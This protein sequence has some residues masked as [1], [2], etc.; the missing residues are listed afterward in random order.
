MLWELMAF[1]RLFL[2]VY[3]GA[4]PSERTKKVRCIEALLKLKQHLLQ[5]VTVVAKDSGQ[6]YEECS[7][8]LSLEAKVIP[9]T[10]AVMTVGGRE[11]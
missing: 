3:I 6:L 10:G 1:E 2:S 4:L 7:Q 11:I 8:Q 5:V 9:H